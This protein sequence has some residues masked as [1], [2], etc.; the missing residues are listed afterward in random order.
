MEQKY[1]LSVQNIIYFQVSHL[2]VCDKTI[3][4]QPLQVTFQ[5]QGGRT[6]FKLKTK[7]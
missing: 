2:D 3:K 7:N 5:Q 6:F 4:I 1:N